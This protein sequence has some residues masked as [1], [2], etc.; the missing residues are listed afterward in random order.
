MSKASFKLSCPAP[1]AVEQSLV[2]MVVTVG[3]AHVSKPNKGSAAYS[4]KMRKKGIGFS[5][6]P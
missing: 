5:P 3:F 2:R 6:R 1:K 4:E